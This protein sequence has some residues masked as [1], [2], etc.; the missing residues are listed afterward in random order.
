MTRLRALTTGDRNVLLAWRNH[1]EVARWMY[2]DH[3]IHQDE[4][5]V[6]FESV[7][8]DQT[9][10]RYRMLDDDGV[11]CALVSLTAID[12]HRRSC[13]WGGYVAPGMTGRGYGTA[14]LELSLELAF[15]ELVLNR[16]WIE[17][18][19]DNDRA[20]RLYENVGF[21]IE[22]HFRQLV[23]RDGRPRD[24]VGLSILR[25][26]WPEDPPTAVGRPAQQQDVR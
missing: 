4:H 2:T 7:A 17:A 10:H 21:Q 23:W 25:S 9:H 24:V 14:A 3:L 22:G 18:L 8:L 1:P 19:A 26:D 13:T 16:V 5:D 15:A 11:A 6:W 12:R 20:I